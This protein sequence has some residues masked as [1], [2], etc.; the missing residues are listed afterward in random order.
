LWRLSSDDKI[1]NNQGE[2]MNSSVEITT[3]NELIKTKDVT[4]FDTPCKA[5]FDIHLI[6]VL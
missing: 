3:I 6:F 4:K 1:A 2:N 5:V